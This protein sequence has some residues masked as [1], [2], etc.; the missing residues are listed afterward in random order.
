[1]YED[2]DQN[3]KE[4]AESFYEN[5]AVCNWC[6]DY[7]NPVKC[8]GLCQSCYRLT[9]TLYRSR[10]DLNEAQATEKSWRIHEA[11]T[12]LRIC[13]LMIEEAK[14][15]GLRFPTTPDRKVTGGDLES[16]FRHLSEIVLNDYDLF[17]GST[18]IFDWH[19]TPGQKKLLFNLIGRILK[20]H[21]RRNRRKRA[22]DKQVREEIATY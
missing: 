14:T 9:R 3:S 22:I 17:F 16:A 19:F 15:E 12:N 11:K 4:F 1:M 5:K 7:E 13:E 2:L 6:K 18:N 8:K 21:S 20:E 10:Q